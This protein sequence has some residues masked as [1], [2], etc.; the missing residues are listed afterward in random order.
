MFKQKVS[1]NLLTSR[2]NHRKNE[3][4]EEPVVFILLLRRNLFFFQQSWR[5]FSIP[6][7]KLSLYTSFTTIVMHCY[8]VVKIYQEGTLFFVNEYLEPNKMS[9]FIKM[10]VSKSSSAETGLCEKSR[11]FSYV[12]WANF[13]LCSW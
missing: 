11:L 6:I 8:G 12:L 13:R 5:R 9:F 2:N 7:Q 10:L 4:N 3:I 1:T